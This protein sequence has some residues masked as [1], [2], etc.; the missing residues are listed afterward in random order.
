MN[1]VFDL[2]IPRLYFAMTETNWYSGLNDSPPTTKTES[3]IEIDAYFDKL[4][5]HDYHR[6]TQ[7]PVDI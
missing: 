4:K 3:S 5:N 2:W 6:N 1:G 7:M